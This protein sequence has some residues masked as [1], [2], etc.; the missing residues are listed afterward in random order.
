LARLKIYTDENGGCAGRRGTV[1]GKFPGLALISGLSSPWS[2]NSA[3]ETDGSA[4][5]L[6][7]R[8]AQDGSEHLTYLL[9]LKMA[10]DE[11]LAGSNSAC[12]IWEGS[13]SERNDVIRVGHMRSAFGQL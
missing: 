13:A 3:L 4:I 6:F 2:K 9:F 11:T 10:D 1:T 12:V 5:G 7:L 8:L